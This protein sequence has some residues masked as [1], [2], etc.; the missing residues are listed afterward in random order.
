MGEMPP[1]KWFDTLCLE[2]TITEDQIKLCSEKWKEL[3]LENLMLRL[4]INGNLVSLHG[5]FLDT[6]IR[7]YLKRM[8]KIFKISRL[9]GEVMGECGLMLSDLV[10]FLG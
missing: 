5:E 6:I 3:Q 1:E 4:M 2:K 8:P 9:I 7:D 10:I